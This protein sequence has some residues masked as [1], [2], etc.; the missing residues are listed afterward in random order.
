LQS[1]T[2]KIIDFE[3]TLNIEVKLKLAHK[4]LLDVIPKI[5]DATLTFQEIKHS[6]ISTMTSIRQELV[7][8]EAS[9]T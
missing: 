7:D 6:Y 4:D 1:T 8:L 3:K 2:E 5:T 9:F